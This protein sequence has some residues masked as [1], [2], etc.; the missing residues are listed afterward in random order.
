MN[1]LLDDLIAMSHYLGDPDRGY[2]MLGEG[3][4][5]ARIDEDTFF[6]KASGTT[7]STIDVTGFVKLSMSRVLAILDDAAA[8]DDDVSRV[9]K[10]ATL[11][12]AGGKRPSVEAMLHA[13]LLQYPEYQ[14]VGHTHPIYMNAILCSNKAEEA[15]AGRI[16][17]DQIVSMGHKSVFVPYVDP[18]LALAREVKQRLE[19]FIAEEGVLPKA[20]VMQNHGL[21]TMGDSPKAVTSC[22]DMAEKAAKII[23][24]TY[25]LGGPRF[26]T[27]ADVDR[28][29][30]RPDEHYRLKSIAGTKQK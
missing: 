20:I 27:K 5:S 23:V 11:D 18:G 30:T 25:A 28:I 12:D 4:T 9:F 1:S 6:V 7:L 29:F 15:A 22:T 24:G 2:A 19:Q 10:E 21:I 17:P 13:I 8:G 3:N 14:F 16:F 26:M